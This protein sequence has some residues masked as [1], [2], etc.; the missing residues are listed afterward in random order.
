MFCS[1][2]G[3]KLPDNAKFCNECGAQIPLTESQPTQAATSVSAFEPVA[4]ESPVSSQSAIQ[5]EG[6][7]TIQSQEDD[8]SEPS[9]QTEESEPT[10]ENENDPKAENKAEPRKKKKIGVGVLIG[11]ISSSFFGIIFLVGL[12]ITFAAD[13]N[14]GNIILI[15]SGVIEIGASVA[16]YKVADYRAKVTCPCCGTKRIHKRIWI[17]T[18]EK[19]NN[20]G[21][22]IHEKI[23]YVH[24]Y[25]D[26]YT[27]PKCGETLKQNIKKNGGYVSNDRQTGQLQDHRIPVREI[28]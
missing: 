5:E 9:A 22:N 26:S 14:V 10:E 1:N 21:S 3:N 23:T 28:L 24:R 17:Q 2:C 15:V 25:L 6:A 12:I 8:I 7:S 18:D 4:D 27:C 20:H 11:I 19:Y 16:L 13:S